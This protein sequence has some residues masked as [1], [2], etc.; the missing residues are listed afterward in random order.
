MQSAKPPSP[1]PQMTATFGR[2]CVFDRKN[3]VVVF[4]DCSRL[5]ILNVVNKTKKVSTFNVSRISFNKF[6]HDF[7]LDNIFA[8][9][10][11]TS[12]QRGIWWQKL[13]NSPPAAFPSHSRLR[14]LLLGLSL[15]SSISFTI[16]HDHPLHFP[17]RKHH[18]IVSLSTMICWKI[19]VNKVWCESYTS[20][21]L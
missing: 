12:K 5:S 11:T 9:L 1:E 18:N 21:I 8:L 20:V 19:C 7:T 6:F 17:T 4:T 10:R 3:S 13:G 15:H 16:K 2:H 14:T